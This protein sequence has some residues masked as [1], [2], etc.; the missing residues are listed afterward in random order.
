[1]P[2]AFAN[3]VALVTGGSRG[4]GR[5]TALR[6]A[7]EGADVAISYASRSLVASQ[8]VAEIEALGRKAICVPCNAARPD[9]VDRLV[10][11]TRE[12]LGPIDLLVHCGA[13]SNITDHTGLTYDLWRETIDVNLNGTFLV[14]D[15]GESCCCLRW[16]PCGRARCRFITRRPR[17]A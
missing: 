8:V 11:M 4:I 5:A 12:K 16:R 14:V 1:M 7:R 3:R 10:S 2:E 15:S 17:R 13:I 6:L 9:D